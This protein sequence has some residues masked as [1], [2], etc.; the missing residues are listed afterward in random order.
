MK[1]IL[2]LGATGYT[3]IQVARALAALGAEVILAARDRAKLDALAR[4]LNV[5]AA[6]VI[7]SPFGA[8]LDALFD[9][10]GVVVDTIG[11]FIQFG[12]PVVAQ[13]IERGVHYVDITGE[14][15]F[16]KR[17]LDRFDDAARERG[18]AVLC[19]QAFE[20][21]LGYGAGALLASEYAPL[22]RLEI[23][24]RTRGG[25]MSHGSAKSTLGI[26]T[27]AAYEYRDGKLQRARPRWNPVA[28]KF[29]D[30]EKIYSAATFPSGENIFLPLNYP[31]LR[32]VGTYLVLPRALAT[33]ALRA[34]A[35][36]I[37]LRALLALPGVRATMERE[38]EKRNPEVAYEAQKQ[39]RFTVLARGTTRTGTVTCRIDGQDAY[40]LTGRIAAQVAV[41]L[42]EG[43]NR[44]VGV[45]STDRAFEPRMFLDSLKAF[46][47]TYALKRE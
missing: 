20:F 16:I 1:P 38:I 9:G 34:N 4:E 41:W 44:D 32:E 23:F 8:N 28:V 35:F 45:L 12:M 31:T 18:I 24:Y 29:P 40:A 6:R 25:A 5:T 19:A 3:G 37:F 11:P 47:V 13:A 2:V 27:H 21:A 7:A 15:V 43:K 39:S 14:Q 33:T 26:F 22:T 10:A 42:A 17:V 30:D 36:G 46:E